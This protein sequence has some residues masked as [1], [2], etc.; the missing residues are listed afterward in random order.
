MRTRNDYTLG[1]V[2]ATLFGLV[3]MAFWFKVPLG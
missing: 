3:A 1:I 2:W